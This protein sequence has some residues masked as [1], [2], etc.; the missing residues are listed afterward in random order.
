MNQ[1][2]QKLLHVVR[3]LIFGVSIENIKKLN[4]VLQDKPWPHQFSSMISIA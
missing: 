3:N 4:P 1:L 2:I